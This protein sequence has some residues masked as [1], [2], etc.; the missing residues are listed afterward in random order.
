MK[1]SYSREKTELGML[2][3]DSVSE[4]N[5]YEVNSGLKVIL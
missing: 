1:F 2:K 5:K 4:T 3:N